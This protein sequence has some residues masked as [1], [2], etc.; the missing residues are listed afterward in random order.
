MAKLTTAKRKSL[1]PSQFAGPDGSYPVEDRAHAIDA[2][3]RATQEENRGLLSAAMAGQ[4][5]AK[6]SK[7]IKRSK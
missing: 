4:I 3:G 5:K 6:A 1:K 2:K 7:V